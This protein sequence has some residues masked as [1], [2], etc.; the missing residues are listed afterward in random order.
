MMI[1]VIQ[2][3]KTHEPEPRGIRINHGFDTMRAVCD[4]ES[5][6]K[7]KRTYQSIPF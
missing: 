2:I 3:Y 6:D 4:H 5:Y 7:D 1:L